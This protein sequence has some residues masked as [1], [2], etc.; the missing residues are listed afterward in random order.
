MRR[1]PSQGFIHLA[2][3]NLRF[4][5]SRFC[6]L[7]FPAVLILA[8]VPLILGQDQVG[9]AVVQQQGQKQEVLAAATTISELG[10]WCQLWE[11]VGGTLRGRMGINS[12]GN[13]L[14]CRESRWNA[15][16]SLAR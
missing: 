13:L 3:M 10:T 5:F 11:Y 4:V 6:L 9:H 7:A 14:Q 16:H 2:T 8:S 1:S 12:G 15:A